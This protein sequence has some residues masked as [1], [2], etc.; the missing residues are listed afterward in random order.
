VRTNDRKT[1]HPIERSPPLKR[2]SRNVA[3]VSVV[4][5]LLV[6]AAALGLTGGP[7]EPAASSPTAVSLDNLVDPFTGDF[8]YSIP[9]FELP[10]PQGSYPFAIS[11][12][13]GIQTE[14]EASWVGLGW[15]FEPG[16]IS[17]TV[18]GLP[19]DVAGEDVHQLFHQRE[20]VAYG[21]TGTVG[22]EVLGLD[23]RLLQIGGDVGLQLF[24]DSYSGYGL[25]LALSQSVGVKLDDNL[26]A[27]LGA[28]ADLNT[29]HG[30]TV[31]ATLGL[32][33]G[34]GKLNPSYGA[35]FNPATGLE[36][37]YWGY[38][39]IPLFS[40]AYVAA[41]QRS[42]WGDRVDFSIKV[43][44]ELWGVFPEGKV[45]G[46]Y[47]KTRYT[48][49]RTRKAYG[50][51]HLTEA[52]N[53]DNAQLDFIREKEGPLKPNTPY[54]PFTTLAHDTFEL[55]T[56]G[57]PAGAFRAYRND[58]PILG[59][60]SVKS[61]NV[62]ARESIEVG[63]GALVHS[64][65]SGQLSTAES[66]SSSW[67]PPRLVEAVHGAPN[68]QERVYFALTSDL[69][70]DKVS[71][72]DE[73]RYV[74]LETTTSLVN[75]A[76]L[77]GLNDS[78][79]VS[80]SDEKRPRATRIRAVTEEEV[81]STTERWGAQFRNITRP[82]NGGK[83]I[84][85]FEVTQ[86]DGTR[87]IFAR[88]AYV[89]K[90]IN[91]SFSVY[92][93][94]SGFHSGQT[95]VPVPDAL[96]PALE[97]WFNSIPPNPG[98]TAS[99]PPLSLPNKT[100][101]FLTCTSTPAYA[102][103]YHLT[104][105]LGVDYVDVTGDGPSD[106]DLGHWVRFDYT[107]VEKY[108]YRSPYFGA[109]YSRG[110][111]RSY[112]T[113]DRGSF[114]Y[115]EKELFVLSRATTASH[116]A[117]FAFSPGA[118]AQ[119]KSCKYDATMEAR[120]DARG[121]WKIVQN[122]GTVPP[123]AGRQPKLV[124]AS[125]CRRGDSVPIKVVS[126]E[127]DYRLA[128]G[129]P[130]G[131][132]NEGKLTLTKVLSQHGKDKSGERSPYEFHYDLSQ[133]GNPDY[134]KAG[135][136]GEK[137]SDRWG[138][139]QACEGLAAYPEDT[140]SGPRC[141]NGDEP[142]TRQSLD[143]DVHPEAW[144]LRAVTTPSRA[145]IEVA[146]EPDDYAF[147]QDQRAGVMV[148]AQVSQGGTCGATVPTTP[149]PT[150]ATPS[151]EVCIDLKSLGFV[152]PPTNHAEATALVE[153][154]VR[155][156]RGDVSQYIAFS[157]DLKLRDDLRD[158]GDRDM[159]DKVSG[160]LEVD[161]TPIVSGCEPTGPCE[162]RIRLR[163]SRA[164][165]TNY[166]PIAFAGWQH[167]R[168]NQPQFAVPG[169]S[170]PGVGQSTD[171][172]LKSQARGLVQMIVRVTN[173]FRDYPASASGEKWASEVKNLKLR[174]FMPTG[175]K[176]GGGVRVKHLRLCE[177]P[178]DCAQGDPA[179]TVGKSYEY[180][181]SDE[182]TGKTI[183]S[184]VAAYEPSLGGDEISVR[185]PE[186]FDDEQ[187][188]WA[189]NDP[190]YFEKPLAE[191]L[192][193]APVV[194]YRRVV[195]RTLAGTLAGKWASDHPDLPPLSLAGERVHEFY[196]AKEFPVR[197][198]A[199]KVQKPPPV[200]DLYPIPGV[201]S[202]LREKFAASQGFRVELND[203]HGKPRRVTELA[204]KTDGS[205]AD[206]ADRQTTYFYNVAG[207]RIDP[208][209]PA[210]HERDRLRIAGTA[211]GQRVEYYADLRQSTSS[212][213]SAGM[214][215]N[216]DVVQVGPWPI[217]IPVP[218]PSY[219]DSET[220]SRTS[221]FHQVVHRGAVLMAVE[222]KDRSVTTQSEHLAF[223]YQRGA[224]ILTSTT[225]AFGAPI[226]D[227]NVPAYWLHDDMRESFNQLAA[228]AITLRS[229]QNPF[230]GSSGMCCQPSNITILR[231]F[232]VLDASASIF[233]RTGF[234]STAFQN[235]LL[236]DEA[237]ALPAWRPIATYRIDDSRRYAASPAP[238]K[239]GR[240]ASPVTFPIS[241]LPEPSTWTTTS[242]D[243]AELF[244]EP[245]SAFDELAASCSASRWK[246]D[247]RFLAY[248]PR[249]PAVHS[250][251]PLG[252]QDAVLYG[253]RA[254][255]VQAVG[256]N[257]GYTD[258]GFESFESYAPGG[259]LT[260]QD[261]DDGNIDFWTVFD[262]V[263][264]TR[265]V[266]RLPG[267]IRD[268]VLVWEKLPPHFAPSF[269]KGNI[270]PIPDVLVRIDSH[271]GEP[272]S[273]EPRIERMEQRGGDI[274][275]VPSEPLPF[276]NREV[277]F[278]LT[279]HVKVPSVTPAHWNAPRGWLGRTWDWLTGKKVP[280]VQVTSAAAHTGTRS[281]SVKGNAVYG[282]TRL[283]PKQAGTYVISVWV[284]RPEANAATFVSGS[285]VEV[286]DRLGIGVVVGGTV[287]EDTET[288]ESVVSGG[289]SSF[290]EPVGPVIDGWQ[291]IE[292]EFQYGTPG[293]A[294]T[295]YLQSGGDVYYVDD[296]RVFPKSTSLQTFVYEPRALRLVARLDDNNMATRWQYD[297]DGQLRFAERETERGWRTIREHVNHLAERP[298][299]SAPGGD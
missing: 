39:N 138:F 77:K 297:Q 265:V 200:Q 125:L 271:L 165:G 62:S 169:V 172:Q 241:R 216:A 225:N 66:E 284:S 170:P 267:R 59:D 153:A 126:F 85:G 249:G 163:P 183:S 112:L 69:S 99:T 219:D 46:Y 196:T 104:S 15:S 250:V 111:E 2:T 36:S 260:L 287:V 146:Y 113:D 107:H 33:V 55:A 248:H 255:V 220:E 12:R 298:K 139:Y 247:E 221:V 210:V 263:P 119:A 150:P 278:E 202:V 264:V 145:R 140:N 115:G 76:T 9:L 240:L 114:T 17:R 294:F 48:M 189:P 30:M 54:L 117:L 178:D 94:D 64:G 118:L 123:A 51:L 108:A 254:A 289:V 203:M 157:T 184:G 275:A 166:H 135:R 11:Y 45:S 152:D 156:A 79:R 277:T 74:A 162:A 192:Y 96:G 181:T 234:I 238:N 103:S 47:S 124:G 274:V 177:G 63:S 132:A 27:N 209:A 84:A 243:P 171:A 194:G 198:E 185:H 148:P 164:G 186:F 149:I 281:L 204:L 244:A 143:A 141:S 296:L 18:R 40:P 285:D 89:K 144:S 293:E 279:R 188:I 136:F 242:N 217:P 211:L 251:T 158:G 44:A 147:V 199:S 128:K 134:Q 65:V 205:P 81:A 168:R 208:S 127:Q 130:N 174:L 50:Y 92:P 29:H 109:H 261:L 207:N 56:S 268:G 28:N 167:L 116:E 235:G 262:I 10:G 22:V 212:T 286:A 78:S 232:D 106:D 270:D 38:A 110:F 259:S 3:R 191:S 43:G 57:G 180:E 230:V 37:A 61:S 179:L 100:D 213:N 151:A 215:F 24:F 276:T 97:S 95:T 49:P 82:E 71:H 253:H 80:W 292:G 129:A 290:F 52:S 8:Q 273:I 25:G 160:Y 83:R 269:D 176:R 190:T 6:P 236:V 266:E 70:T 75:P 14:Q 1:Q 173:V 23:N 19:D 206:G 98:A 87:Y 142:Y 26:G 193:P 288:K 137:N 295:I 231:V 21:F 120:A 91:C 258:I 222:T 201:G 42:Q 154:L 53:R 86:P 101:Q 291:R 155:N 197:A 88:P 299:A 73:P 159:W 102:H 60:P 227:L 280:K 252:R 133:T 105:V 58:I 122:G 5:A 195:E 90:E 223:D 68:P 20:A 218:W 257:A 229:A 131:G 282:Q 175:K 214:S 239:D 16:R 224:P 67:L 93:K 35:S 228:N 256:Q 182:V 121:A 31:G 246:R 272:F 226:F 187:R 161:G 237:H 32:N 245:L 233:G 34:M 283:A 13:S 72:A 41:A 7:S 4:L